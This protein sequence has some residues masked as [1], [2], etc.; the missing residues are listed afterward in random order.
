MERQFDGAAGEL[1]VL[2]GGCGGGRDLKGFKDAGLLAE[3]LEPSEAMAEIAT[4]YSGCTVHN[5][6]FEGMDFEDGR[7]HG[8]FCLA[9]LFHLPIQQLNGV[10]REFLRIL[11]NSHDK[12]RFA[13]RILKNS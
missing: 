6:D 3:G 2:D 5:T 7:F 10:L 8:I 4:A 11:V 13:F 1:R 12:P 9:S